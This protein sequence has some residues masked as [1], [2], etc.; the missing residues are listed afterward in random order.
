MRLPADGHGHTPVPAIRHNE[1]AGTSAFVHQRR[2]LCKSPP[3]IREPPPCPPMLPCHRLSPPCMATTR[4]AR[5][6]SRRMHRVRDI[7]I[8]RHSPTPSGVF[9]RHRAWNCPCWPIV[10]SPHSLRCVLV[11]F[12]LCLWLFV[13]VLRVCWCF[14]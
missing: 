3:S 14:R 4:R 10:C 8:G 1:F 7:S 2:L 9:M 5:T 6:G 11:L 13:S 12:F